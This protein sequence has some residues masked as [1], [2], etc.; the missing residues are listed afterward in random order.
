MIDYARMNREGPALKAALTRAVNSKDPIKVVEAC[1]KAVNAWDAI[2]AWPDQWHRWN[3][4]LGDAIGW[5]TSLQDLANMSNT[6]YV[7]LKMRVTAQ[8]GEVW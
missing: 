3:I 5:G 1:W 8:K 7:D 2:G 6:Q 4:A